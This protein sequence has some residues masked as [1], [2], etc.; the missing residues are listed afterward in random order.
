MLFAAFWG[1]FKKSHKKFEK[2]F[3]KCLILFIY[4]DKIFN[5][6]AFERE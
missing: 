1:F 4:Y 3:K 5:I 2:I 6:N